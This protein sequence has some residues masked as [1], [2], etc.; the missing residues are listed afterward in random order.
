M[1]Q[2]NNTA[3]GIAGDMSH[4]APHQVEECR[5]GEAGA[6]RTSLRRTCHSPPHRSAQFQLAFVS[7]SREVHGKSRLLPFLGPPF[8]ASC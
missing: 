7:K 1:E 5:G 2:A 4:R 6:R 8:L 3:A